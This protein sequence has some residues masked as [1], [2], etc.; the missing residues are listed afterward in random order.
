MTKIV[1]EIP[2]QGD[3]QLL[4]AFAKQLNATVVEI[5]EKKN[6]EAKKSP[7]YWLEELSKI[8]SFKEIISPLEWQR[9]VRKD[10]TLP[11]RN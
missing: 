8:E 5:K 3:L 1:L 6:I 4:I 7:I 11:V 10:R 2:N 9:A